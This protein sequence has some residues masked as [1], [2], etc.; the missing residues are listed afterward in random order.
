MAEFERTAGV[1]H[2]GGAHSVHPGM[3]VEDG[4]HAGML[5]VDHPMLDG[6]HGYPPGLDARGKAENHGVFVRLVTF[7]EQNIPPDLHQG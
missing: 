6:V 7:H 4:P 2:V 3:N 5:P 1:I